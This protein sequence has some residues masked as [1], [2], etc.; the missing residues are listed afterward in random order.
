MYKILRNIFNSNISDSEII[1]EIE[2]MKHN[3]P[4]FD[5]NWIDKDPR[6]AIWS[7]LMNAVH[8]DRIELVKYLFTY[9]DINVN[10]SSEFN[11]STAFHNCVKKDKM[12]GLFLSREDTNVNVVDNM[13]YTYSHN[14]I[15]WEKNKYAKT[16]EL[17]LDART[18]TSIRDMFGRTA[19][20]LA[21]SY[22]YHRIAKI[23]DNTRYTILLRIPNG[24]LIYDI[25]R[26]I[27]C[28][29]T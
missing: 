20:E 6:T 29:Y 27:I 23:I 25:A 19:Q 21:K 2:Y 7:L 22:G 1:Q 5:V 14:I 28:K 15:Y 24:M 4:K 16:K 18:D 17:L 11:K 26:M 8:C 10:Y 9:S 3:D 12:F 13:G